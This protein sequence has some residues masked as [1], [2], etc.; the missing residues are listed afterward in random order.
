[1]FFRLGSLVPNLAPEEVANKAHVSSLRNIVDNPLNVPHSLPQH[2]LIRLNQKSVAATRV[3]SAIWG[4]VFVG[5]FYYIVRR[6]HTTRIA[7]WSTLFFAA[8][9]WFLHIARLGTPY[10][11]LFMPLA[12]M[13]YGTWLTRTKKSTWALVIG[14]L[15]FST[16]LY[17]PAMVWIMVASLIWQRRRIR[18]LYQ[19]S[20]VLW[21]ILTVLGL[22]VGLL[23]LAY[24]LYKNPSLA[25]N[26]AGLPQHLPNFL[27][28]GKNLIRLPIEL[29]IK[30]PDN[31]VLW[32]GTTPIFDIFTAT[33]ALLGLYAYYYRRALDRS[34][35]LAG[36]IVFGVVLTV[37]QNIV[38][39]TLLIPVVYLCV[40]TG[41]TLMLQ[42]WF[43]VFPRN[44]LARSVGA[45]LLVITILMAVIYNINHYFY[46][47]PNA[48]ETKATFVATE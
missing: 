21:K 18:G 5:C 36:L 25:W 8:S 48:P 2:A 4:L 10:V 9:S 34:G 6:W 28:V 44:P 23:P 16:A 37:F 26:V 11:L 47:W 7:I 3:V 46:A 14:V 19:K 30:G 45:S 40:A 32:L 17:V 42:Q 35:A 24:A 15:L 43:T 20:H 27:D 29:V 38:Y 13:A 12:F 41:I 33:M 39:V 1:M 31:P 22:L